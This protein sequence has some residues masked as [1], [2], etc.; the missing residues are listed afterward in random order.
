MWHYRGWRSKQSA[1]YP[2]SHLCSMSPV[3]AQVPIRKTIRPFYTNRSSVF[4]LCGSSFVLVECCLW[5]I[6]VELE[7]CFCKFSF[8]V[9]SHCSRASVACGY[10]FQLRPLVEVNRELLKHLLR[11]HKHSHTL[12]IVIESICLIWCV[13]CFKRLLLLDS[14]VKSHSSDK[15]LCPLIA[16][17]HL[18]YCQCKSLTKV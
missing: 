4:C 11:Q 18:D 5:P 2:R 1:A 10:V 17:L 3:L 6:M 15:S 13:C 16:I 7:R 12:E 8:V 14:F 9:S